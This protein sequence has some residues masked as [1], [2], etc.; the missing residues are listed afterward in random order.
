MGIPSEQKIQICSETM[1]GLA[2]ALCLGLK[3]ST[4]NN[5]NQNH[6]CPRLE[7]LAERSQF[8]CSTGTSC[9]AICACGLPQAGFKRGLHTHTVWCKTKVSQKWV[10]V[11]LRMNKTK[12]LQKEVPKK[13]IHLFLPFHILPSRWL[14]LNLLKRPTE[15]PQQLRERDGGMGVVWEYTLLLFRLHMPISQP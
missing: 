15:Q 8:S 9:F 12:Q 3:H 2:V 11:L 10:G 6:E 5:C 7:A 13:I 4:A 14:L 1:A